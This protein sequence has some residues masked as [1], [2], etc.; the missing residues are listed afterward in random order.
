M[1]KTKNLGVITKNHTPPEH[2]LKKGSA[3]RTS[4][5]MSTIE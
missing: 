2:Y 4:T 1:K 5:L 3:I